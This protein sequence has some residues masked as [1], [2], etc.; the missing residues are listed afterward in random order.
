[1]PSAA[2][3]SAE[4]LDEV[5]T[6]SAT[7]SS[8][9]I[10]PAPSVDDVVVAPPTDVPTT[11]DAVAVGDDAAAAASDPMVADVAV[12]MGASEATWVA[13]GVPGTGGGGADD[14]A[15]VGDGVVGGGELDDGVPQSEPFRGL[16]GSPSIGGGG[17]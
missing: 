1:M 3:E 12:A 13:G 7:A 16:E 14:G 8:A 15:A 4:M 10:D 9:T 2:L 11:D 5:V 17:A 6:P